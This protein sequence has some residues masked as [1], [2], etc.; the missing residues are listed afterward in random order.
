MTMDIALITAG[1]MYRYHL[2]QTVVGDGRRPARTSLVKA[3][4]EAGVPVGRWM[5]RGLA[6]LGLAVGDVVTE[7]QLR[8]LFGERGRH[9]HADLIEADL[10]AEGKSPKAAWK[11]GALG[12]RVKVTGFDLVFRPQP[13][14]YLL[15]ALGDDETRRVIE[16][17]HERAIQRVL[18]WIEDQV[19]VI[20]FGKDG[21]YQVRP[22]GSLVAARFRH[23]EARSGMPLLHD[24]LW[25]SVKGQRLDG[26]WGSVHSEVMFE[27]TVAASALY[28]EIVMAEVCEALGLASE[29][30]TVTPGRRPVME[31]AG[32]PH[33]LIRWTSRR[34]AQIAACLTDLEREY[35]T[36]TDDD[37]NLKFGPE[38]SERTRA[39]LNRIAALKTR[40]AKPRPRS[41][42]QLRQDWRDSAR[43]FL[44]AGADLIDSLLERARAAAAASWPGSP[45]SS[46]SAWRPSPSP[47][48]CS[49]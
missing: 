30:R 41:L 18:E 38:V 3:Q 28:S 44:A 11:A 15:W 37:G 19:A 31:V 29:P 35:V 46:T 49:S 16:A 32:V 34:S 7:A 43:A 21:V 40:P 39:K 45:P 48:P 42:T 9:P 5:G 2:R 36:A 22:S 14:I 27:N 8:N 1:Q 33:E 4:E 12:R 25:L 17:T 10:L 24:H 13:T 47:P 20:R 26:K 6:A 23:Y